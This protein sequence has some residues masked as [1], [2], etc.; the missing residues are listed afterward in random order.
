[1][2]AGDSIEEE[3]QRRDNGRSKMRGQCR[4]IMQFINT[5]DYDGG[6]VAK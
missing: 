6:V 4:Q 1:M 3:H 5:G 2:I